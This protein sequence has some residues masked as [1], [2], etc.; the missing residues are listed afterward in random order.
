MG[1]SSGSQ[2]LVAEVSGSSVFVSFGYCLP[3]IAIVAATHLRAADLVFFKNGPNPASFVYFHPFHV[4]N[5]AKIYK[6]IDGVLGIR[7][8]VA[9]W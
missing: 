9:G 7:T 3:F 8:R 2:R 6:S 5:I 4:T 1:I